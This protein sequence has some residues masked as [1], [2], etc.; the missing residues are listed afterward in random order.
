LQRRHAVLVGGNVGFD[1]EQGFGQH[2]IVATL[3]ERIGVGASAVDKEVG[4]VP[5]VEK[6]EKRL[7]DELLV[8][9]ELDKALALLLL[10]RSSLVLACMLPVVT[11]TILE[12]VWSSG[13]KDDKGAS[14]NVC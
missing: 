3:R 13:N 2:N 9:L 10:E 1:A 5:G 8:F 7:D 12:E 4:V 14:K 11:T 6:R